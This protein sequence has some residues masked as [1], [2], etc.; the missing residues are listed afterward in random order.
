MRSG[1]HSL[2]LG[3]SALVTWSHDWSQT[4]RQPLLRALREREKESRHD[5]TIYNGLSALKL[6]L[7]WSDWP[8]KAA[9]CWWDSL[10]V[11]DCCVPGPG[12]A[13]PV[14]AAAARAGHELSS[15]AVLTPQA[16]TWAQSQL[17]LRA[18]SHDTRARAHWGAVTWPLIMCLLELTTGIH[19]NALCANTVVTGHQSGVSERVWQ[20]IR[21]CPFDYRYQKSSQY[22]HIVRSHC[23][24]HKMSIPDTEKCWQ[25]RVYQVRGY[26]NH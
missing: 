13:Q 18:Q 16:W 26:G 7:N 25:E 2:R 23:P 24:G 19:C 10:G 20:Q 11:R 1:L 17:R 4:R 3:S 12:P 6:I 21:Q 9:P 5:K 15:P 22:W 8:L 14:E